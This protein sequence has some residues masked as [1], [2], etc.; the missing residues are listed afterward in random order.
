MKLFVLVLIALLLIPFSSFSQNLSP[1]TQPDCVY[2]LTGESYSGSDSSF[3][4]KYY[5]G[6]R[7]KSC[8]GF[9]ATDTGVIMMWLTRNTTEI[10]FP[11]YVKPGFEKELH[12][13]QFKKIYQSGTTV[14][15]SEIWVF[16]DN[17][18]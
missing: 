5:N 12:A 6:E 15:L 4:P 13:I 7:I 2:N 3:I 9:M 14:D 1:I 11:Y 18:N 17:A 16:P 8:K 10:R